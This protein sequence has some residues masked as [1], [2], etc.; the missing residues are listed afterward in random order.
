MGRVS[1]ERLPGSNVKDSYLVDGMR[2]E[3][4]QKGLNILRMTDG[5]VKKVVRK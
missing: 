1:P 5:T 2:T 3:G 4:L